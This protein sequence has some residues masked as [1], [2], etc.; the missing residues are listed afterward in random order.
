MAQEKGKPTVETVQ[1]E[2]K[3]SDLL[4]Y[5]VCTPLK[6]QLDKIKICTPSIAVCLPNENCPPM[7]V[8]IPKCE[9]LAHCKHVDPD[10]CIPSFA[11]GPWGPCKPV[12]PNPNLSPNL[13]RQKL[14]VSDLEQLNAEVEKLK[15]EIE[16]LKGKI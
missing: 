12:D 2:A 1:Q 13:L 7:W 8:P 4:M 9:P 10:F 5:E 16:I 15:K 14:L 3:A 11:C 6:E